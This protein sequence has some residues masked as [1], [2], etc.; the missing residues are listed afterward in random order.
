MPFY[1]LLTKQR[2]IRGEWL[3]EMGNGVYAKWKNRTMIRD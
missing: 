1:N 2:Q 3:T